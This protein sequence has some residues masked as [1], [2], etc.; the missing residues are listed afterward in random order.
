M[1]RKA[2]APE[3][4]R[5]TITPKLLEMF[6]RVLRLELDGSYDAWENEG[7]NREEWRTLLCEITDTLSVPVAD[8]CTNGMDSGPA[9]WIK[10]HPELL[11]VVASGANDSLIFR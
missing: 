2:P 1:E 11:E 3:D 10:R 9:D 6:E 8:I 4:D 5:V 7:G